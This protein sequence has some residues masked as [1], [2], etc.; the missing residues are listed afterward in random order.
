MV[1]EFKFPDVG[2][3][4]TEGELVKWLVAEGDSVKVDQHICEVETDKAVVEMPSPK[5]GKIQKLLFKAG[6]TIK[7]GEVFVL[8][9]DGSAEGPSAPVK[10][11]THP[12]E[13]KKKE[14][15]EKYTG[16]VVGFLEEAKEISP[17]QQSAQVSSSQPERKKVKATLMI[18]KL[19]KEKGVDIT[20]LTG[21][22]PDGRI[23]KEDVEKA[24]KGEAPQTP[25]KPSQTAPEQPV[26]AG[27][28]KHVKKYDMF[29]YLERQPLKGIR[30]K[31]AKVMATAHTQIPPVTNHQEADVTELEILR[32]HEKE[33]L[34]AE[35]IKLTSLTYIV[36]AVTDA[37]QKHPL[38]NAILEDETVV[39]KKY[40][41][42]GVAVETEAGL[43]VPVIKRTNTKNIK[44]IAAE[45][46]KLADEAKSR[47]INLMDLKGASFS[48][49]NIGGIGNVEYFTPII[50]PPEV[51]ILGIG[52]TQ[53]KPVVRNGKVEV[54]KMMPLSLTFDHR[55]VDGVAATLFM[56]DVV[57]NLEN[58]SSLGK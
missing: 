46:Q 33:A 35:N 22:G 57:K 3:G 4:I 39:M 18:R 55:V 58:A 26:T 10:E 49:T 7:V 2:E 37:L 1:Y 21:T 8:I 25:A 16:S 56:E 53:E 27:G 45:I 42:I 13:D 24:P 32:K 15:E 19:A 41:N 12:P 50:N 36:K 43:M 38:L 11:E 34:K 51:A 44:E 48:I 9:D 6:D 14:G 28:G 23:T 30:K 52:R 47:K 17:V 54:R 29:G 31:A 20:T 40:Y 5:A